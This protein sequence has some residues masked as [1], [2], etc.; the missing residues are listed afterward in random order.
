MSIAEMKKKKEKMIA[1]I[2]ALPED[3]LAS[4]EA[5]IDEINEI[6]NNDSI[7]YIYRKAVDQYHETLQKL[8]Q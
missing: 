6:K 7:D 4:V 2:N 5:F 1:V 8:A 3:K